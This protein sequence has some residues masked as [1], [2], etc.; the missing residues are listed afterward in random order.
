MALIATAISAFVA[1]SC[2]LFVSL[3]GLND[4]GGSAPDGS[5]ASDAGTTKDA[6]FVNDAS[7]DAPPC[8]PAERVQ[9]VF[10]TD[11]GGNDDSLTVSLPSL[12]EANDFLV[13][14]VNYFDC[15]SIASITDTAGNTYKSLVPAAGDNDNSGMLETWGAA[16]IARSPTNV[17]TVHFAKVCDG[18]NVKVIEYSGIDAFSPVDSTATMFG[19]GGSAPD[20]GLTASAAAVLFAHTADARMSDGPGSG[21]TEVFTDDWGTLAE[22]RFATTSGSFV[23]TYKPSS[24]D[25]WGIE[26]VSLRACKSP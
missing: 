13:V 12:E 10:G 21:W 1:T 3:D 8:V 11:D 2:S 20:A 19:S 24:T 23:A 25:I 26:A 14:G 18:R 16:N 5:T 15:G 9:F 6:A 22:E 17:I 7:L 4:N